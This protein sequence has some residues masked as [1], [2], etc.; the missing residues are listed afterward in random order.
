LQQRAASLLEHLSKDE[1]GAAVE[2]FDEVMRGALPEQKLEEMWN[3]MIASLGALKSLGDSKV[4][5]EAGYQ[6]VLQPCEFEKGR[7]DAKVVFDKEG[8]ITGFWFLPPSSAADYTPPA[9]ANKGKFIEEEIT[10]GAEGWELPGTITLPK[11]KGPFPA[12]VLVHGSGSN[13]RDETI[14]SNK[15]FK[16]LAWGLATHGIAV[17][18]YDKRTNV[19]G[20]KIDP[21]KITVEGEVIED[22]LLALDFLRQQEGIDG[23]KVFLLGHSLGG[24]LA[25][26]IAN[27]D[28]KVAGVIVLAGNTR[29]LQEMLLEQ[30]EY[31][32]SLDGE[33]SKEEAEGLRKIERGVEAINSH[34]L[35]EDEIVP[36]LGGSVRYWYDLQERDAIQE[37]LELSCPL[38]ILQGGRDYQVTMEDFKG[39]QEGLA[40]K[41]NVSFNL[42]PNLSHLFVAGKGKST[43]SEYQQPGNVDEQVI[44]DIA[45]WIATATNTVSAA[46]YA[47]A[48]S[49]SQ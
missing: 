35:E 15:P 36:G 32:F 21:L 47:L 9:Y 22:A 11:S 29:P 13:N 12:I 30:M 14:G 18:R 49:S 41:E 43:P 48:G 42:Y 45:D 31:I 6:I 4:Y 40:S 8:C 24:G 39:W 20:M 33:I 23:N 27:R 16:D 26:E 25:P 28:G 3:G 34:Q 17:L 2:Q 44:E 19:Y 37:A 46:V 5:E 10:F 38:L 7:L 1:Y